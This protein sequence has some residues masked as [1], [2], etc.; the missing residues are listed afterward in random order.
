MIPYTYRD[1]VLR[2]YYDHRV[3]FIGDAAHCM[4]P[5]LGQG[6]NMGLIAVPFTK[7]TMLNTLSGRIA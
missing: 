2:K 6:A 1:V 4:S 5:Q 7:N 3:V